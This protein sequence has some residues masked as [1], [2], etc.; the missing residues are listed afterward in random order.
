MPLKRRNYS[1]FPS[2][3][4]WVDLNMST[5]S[6]YHHLSWLLLLISIYVFLFVKLGSAHIRLWD[7][8]WFAVHAVEMMQQ[9]S[10]FVSYFDGLPSVTSSK[11]PLQTWFQIA[12]MQVFGMNELALRLPSALAAA[13]IVLV[14][15]FFTKRVANDSIAWY[16]AFILLTSIG[17]IGFHT[18]RGA[19]ADS[20]LTL[21]LV[22]QSLAFF[23][24]TQDRSPKWIWALGA[25]IALGFW[26]KSVATF[27]FIPGMLAY[28]LLF[29][30]TLLSTSIVSPHFYGAI[31]LAVAGIG[32]YIFIREQAQPGYLA[33]FFKSNVGRYTRTVGH[34]Q[35]LSYYLRH[36]LDGRYAFWIGFALFGMI[37]AFIQ[38]E[39]V[40][41]WVLFSSVIAIAYVLV[42]SFSQSKLPWYDMPFYPMAAIGG[43]YAISELVRSQ[44]GLR[45]SLLVAALFVL[46]SYQMFAHT[47]ANRLNLQEMAFEAQEIYL[48]KALRKGADLNETW[49]VHDHFKG[50][51]LFYS[52][53]FENRNQRLR[54][55]N[56]MESIKSGDR[57]LISNEAFM[58]TLQAQFQ[59]DS[60]DGYRNAVLF[61]VG[62]PE[63]TINSK[64]QIND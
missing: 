11:P 64:P 48:S 28:V 51:L 33:M 62:A 23:R 4:V 41:P 14:L 8:G 42:I 2:R 30:R 45:R 25:L 12:S 32:L 52:H 55:T 60:L 50:S 29:D 3:E 26:A 44:R 5:P 34:D 40:A 9:G 6:K 53:C 31:I 38:R 1:A 58:T 10:W 35:P 61:Q 49:V 63:Q 18:A 16:A 22:L 46:P 27:L 54:L 39:T 19:E 37:L 43:A 59:L 21:F 47:Q 56:N 20:L 24:Y 13:A 7:E 36:F 57:V 15:F 17:F